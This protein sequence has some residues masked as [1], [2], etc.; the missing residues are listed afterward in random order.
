MS[1]CYL[2]AS[3]LPILITL[4][5]IF[6][7]SFFI[8]FFMTFTFDTACRVFQITLKDGGVMEN[9]AEFFL[10]GDKDLR[11]SEFDHFNLF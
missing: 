9:F 7:M 11:R 1:V 5:L 6:C 4:H 10:L 8:F 2:I 3:Y